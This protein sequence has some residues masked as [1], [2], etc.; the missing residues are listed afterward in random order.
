MENVNLS[1]LKV[2]ED[3]SDEAIYEDI[4]SDLEDSLKEYSETDLIV[5]LIQNA[6]DAMDE[7]RYQNIC[8]RLAVDPT[9]A[10]TILAWNKTVTDVISADF[11]S[12]PN[13]GSTAAK[14]VWQSGKSD[15][16]KARRRWAEV[17]IS[18]LAL[19]EESVEAVLN[20]QPADWAQLK[21]SIE[22]TN[23][24][25]LTITD[26]GVGMANPLTAFRHKGSTKRRRG[27]N[28]RLGIRGSH[29]W[30][31][32]AILGLCNRVEVVSKT[33]NSSVTG[34]L[35]ENFASFRA[36]SGV[37]PS[38]TVAG[39]D[40]LS[41]LGLP[42]E[43]LGES[44]TVVRVTLPE[45]HE[46]GLLKALISEGSFDQWA[47][48]LRLHTPV[49]QVND[50][51]LHP[52]YHCLR[53]S[54]VSV[55]LEWVKG[56]DRQV[57]GI[58]FDYFRLSDL[59]PER[60]V[61][62]EQFV[63]MGMTA[64]KS[65]YCV[66]RE[67]SGP[68]IYLF[69]AEVQ[70]SKPTLQAIEENEPSLTSYTTD[71]GEVAPGIPRGIF[72]ALS[73]GMRSEY[74]ALPAL[75]TNAAY[76]GVILAETAQA[77]LGRKHTLDQRTSIPRAARAFTSSYE[78]VRKHTIPSGQP[79]L[80]GPA[81]HKWLQNL[82]ANVISELEDDPPRAE[83]GIWASSGS[84]EARSMLCYAELLGRGFFGATKVLRCSLRDVYDFQFVY[85]WSIQAGI[86]P[87]GPMS[88]TLVQEGYVVK[89]DA[90]YRRLAIGEFKGQGD[91]ILKEFD[92][93]GSDWR[94]NP[95]SID[96]LVCWDFDE[97]ALG[98]SWTSIETD[99]G[100]DL[101]EFGG[102]THI[103]QPAA[104]GPRSRNLSV[105]SLSHLIDRLIRKQKL[106]PQGGW[107]TFVG[108]NYY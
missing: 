82:W 1:K 31:L 88:E 3:A 49:G 17:L 12:F 7:R 19:S 90:G 93:S 79:I 107:A 65:V 58:L 35:L 78:D 43:I 96:L 55:T 39:Q 69:G 16:V 108:Q 23:P 54:D 15:E 63:N 75:S 47:T 66:G 95:N 51:V 28:R 32:S 80:T 44:G 40:E 37:T 86:G 42:A 81:L 99:E 76:R 98:E 29:G 64:G 25:R 101:H 77:T 84:G 83:L 67:K 53:K 87:T 104:G 24:N 59:K 8:E 91:T 70:A 52:A 34:L 11:D 62:L 102:Q 26:S 36:G 41:I 50:Y 27:N 94:K 103:W 18:N 100:G 6:L 72:L 5:E 48:M 21:V 71:A 92:A 2:Q 74:V 68:N 4:R 46:S 60:C 10:T 33:I 106:S 38:I 13:T 14:A 30:G 57:A 61:N 20:E 105:V 22:L 56:M 9:E 97:S 89:E 73:G 45:I 85:R